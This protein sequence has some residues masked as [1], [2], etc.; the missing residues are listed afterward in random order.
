MQELLL[1]VHF[2]FFSFISSKQEISRSYDTQTE[3]KS[4]GFHLFFCRSNP[5]LMLPCYSQVNVHSPSFVCVFNFI[6]CLYRDSVVRY[7]VKTCQGK[8][9][10]KR[11]TALGTC[12]TNIRQSLNAA[13]CKPAREAV[14]E[15]RAERRRRRRPSQSYRGNRT[16]LLDFNF[17]VRETF[18]LSDEGRRRLSF[19]SPRLNSKS[20]CGSEGIHNLHPLSD[21]SSDY[22]VRW[23]QLK[24]TKQG[25]IS[26][27]VF[28]LSVHARQV[29]LQG[30][31]LKVDVSPECC[32]C[33]GAEP[34][35]VTTEPLVQRDERSVT[36]SGMFRSGA[37]ADGCRLV[38]RRLQ[39][40]SAIL[41]PF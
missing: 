3:V 16:H 9:Y 20:G 26:R 5:H 31:K 1:K 8:M 6:L 18:R 2:L 33:F 28:C 7:Y 30:W 24:V 25:F 38:S 17:L 19:T 13:S 35:L 39:V 29:S 32:G 40:H 36:C 4:Q 22:Y 11:V 14:I 23:R 15:R 10:R 41:C 21:W 34:L 12:L 27:N 37:A